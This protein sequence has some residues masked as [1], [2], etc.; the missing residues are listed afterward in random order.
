MTTSFEQAF[1]AVSILVRDF[2]EHEAHYLSPSY[3]EAEVR[4]DFLNKFFIALGWDVRHVEQTNPRE[5]EVKVEKNPDASASGR[6]AD[7]AFYLKPDYK[8][9]VFFCE[10]K[11]PSRKLGDP[12]FYFQLVRYGRGAGVPISIL[13]DFEEFHIVDC[14]YE[15]HI[16]KSYPSAQINNFSYK[17]YLDRDKFG[18]IYWLFSR[19]AVEQGKLKEFAKQ[20][21][22]QR[23]KGKAKLTA[24]EAKPVDEA[25]L[26]KL[27]EYR[28]T[29]AKA[30]KKADD[31]LTAGDLTEATQKVIDRLVFIRF[32]EDKNIESDYIIDEIAAKR[33]YK[34]TPPFQGINKDTPPFQGGA[35]VVDPKLSAAPESTPQPPLKRGANLSELKSEAT[36]SS[37]KRG[38]SWSSFLAWSKELDVKY[39]GVVFK[40]HDIDKPTFKA[41]DDKVFASLCAD[42]SHRQSK[43]LFS[44]IPIEILGSIYERFLGKVVTATAKRADIEYKPEVRKAGGVYYTPKYIVD[45][46]VENTVGKI[47]TNNTEGINKNTPPFQGGDGVVDP[48]LSADPEST[49][50]PPLK[51]GADLRGLKRG[52]DSVSASSSLNPKNISKLKFADIACGSGSFLIAVY[53]K[54][55][56]HVEHYYN[57]HPDEAK[58]AGCIEIDKGIYS[59]S[60]KQKQQILLDNIFGVDID[61]QAVEVAQLSLFL[62]LLEGESGASTGQLSFEKTKILPDLSKNIVCGNS[63]VEYDI[64]NQLPLLSKEGVQGVVEHSA[65]STINPFD[66]K[67][68]FKDIMAKG[69]FDAIVGNPPWSSKIP[70][71]LN[72]YLSKKYSVDGKNVNLFALFY[73]RCLELLNNKGIQGILVPKV[74]IKN[75]SYTEIRK[76]VLINFDVI[77]LADFGKFPGVASDCVCSFIRGGEKTNSLTLV[78]KFDDKGEIIED[79]N[80]DSNIFLQ[81]PIYAFSFDID[82][83]KQHILDIIKRLSISINDICNVK[84]GIEL[85][86]E[87]LIIKCNHCNSYNEFGQKYYNIGKVITC[88][89]CKEKIDLKSKPIQISSRT[90]DQ[91]YVLP[92]ISGK[93]VDRYFIKET[94]FILEGL[95]GIEYKPD[96]SVGDRVMMKRIATYP[97]AIFASN[98]L[99]SFNTVYVLYD[100]K[101]FS[102]KFLTGFLNSNLIRFVYEN[103][104]NIGMN[105]TSQITIE[106]LKQIPIRNLDLSNVADKQKHDTISKLVDQM[107]ETKKQLANSK[108]ESEQAQLKRKCEYLDNEIDKLVY[109]L[110]GLTEEEIKIVEGV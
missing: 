110:Y 82:F 24:E 59:L 46:I 83:S 92:C 56:H 4:E 81:N 99:F 18:Y 9:P 40:P 19:E 80:I 33:I 27:E 12:E 97:V 85:G 100:V 101:Q 54:I 43:Y 7:Y 20:L 49:P 10:A 42:I 107:L 109:E 60:L 45:Y 1:E 52:T 47:L 72:S 91:H 57:E 34:D 11:K 21:P 58:K 44:Y 15:P 28:L 89:T 51:R 86:Q 53:D 78:R 66:F 30:F 98:L 29:L 36:I 105:L 95:K 68:S 2:A 17:D 39:N 96:I 6:K 16:D 65:L 76:R 25:F 31:T 106:Y 62:K 108:R 32:L 77:E 102:P 70:L 75:T 104:F 14:R 94:Y 87:A 74:F 37:G 69:G 50:Q 67:T 64:E 79:K 48:K 84:R 8:N 90:K 13:T 23:G 41:P 88:K 55:L 3:Q 5:Q 22:K 63:L 61:H 73:L 35:G 103:L 26:T 93:T 38:G 71:A